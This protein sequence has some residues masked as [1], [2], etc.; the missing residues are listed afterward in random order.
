MVKTIKWQGKGRGRGRG[1]RGGS[2]RVAVHQEGGGQQ[3]SPLQKVRSKN[4]RPRRG[5]WR[6]GREQELKDKERQF[7]EDVKKKAEERLAD[8][9]EHLKQFQTDQGTQTEKMSTIKVEESASTSGQNNKPA[10]K[11]QDETKKAMQGNKVEEECIAECNPGKNNSCYRRSRKRIDG[12]LSCIEVKL[13]LQGMGIE[14]L[15]DINRCTLSAIQTG[16]IQVQGKPEDLDMVVFEEKADCG[17]MFKATLKQLLEQPDYNGNDCG[18]SATVR[19][20]ENP[21]G[22]WDSACWGQYVRDIC[23]GR[24]CLDNGK[25]HNHCRGCPGFGRCLNDYRSSCYNR[26]G[27]HTNKVYFVGGRYNTW[28]DDSSPDSELDFTDSDQD[29]SIFSWFK[30]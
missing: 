3:L 15:E 9:N 7:W 2:G 29:F 19:C 17:H 22:N 12:H 21:D 28:T 10:P 26:Q 8:A 6:A 4:R 14:S 30:H 27:V 5:I 23:S 25:G 11:Q 1:G 20:P 18:E 13:L 16:I 24:P